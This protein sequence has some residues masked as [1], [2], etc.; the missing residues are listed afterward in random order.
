MH[1]RP[2]GRCP[3]TIAPTDPLMQVNRPV[4]QQSW[5]IDAVYASKVDTLVVCRPILSVDPDELAS[6]I[7][8]AQGDIVITGKGPFSA[9]AIHVNLPQLWMQH[10]EEKLPRVWHNAASSTRGAIWFYTKPGPAAVFQGTEL[11]DNQIG[12]CPVAQPIWQRLTGPSSWGSMSLPLDAWT[13]L[14][15]AAGSDLFA[16]QA[17]TIFRPSEADIER[18]RRLQQSTARLAQDAPDLFMNADVARG[19]EQS[20]IH[21]MTLCFQLPGNE[22]FG[23]SAWNRSRVMRAFK[24]FLEE[25]GDTPI[26]VPE[27]CTRLRIAER[28]LR[29]ICHEY[30]GMGPKKYLY[31]R[32]MHLARRALRGGDGAAATSVTEVAMRYGFCELGRFSVAYR[33]LFGELP[34]ATLRQSP[35]NCA[36]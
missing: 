19:I 36:L 5:A 35:I 12:V 18:L 27:L 4:L 3:P 11:S 21:A 6:M 20:L 2:V 17:G 31:L 15:T 7:R 10:V 25:S 30:I 1:F 29:T 9:K 13:N 16:T 28:T 22:E 8:P 34:S 26:Y 14:S 32:R 33:D 24:Q 23:C